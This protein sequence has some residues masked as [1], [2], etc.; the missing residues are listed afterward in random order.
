MM[1][2][3]AVVLRRD[4]GYFNKKPLLKVPLMKA[5]LERFLTY[6][7]YR[8][9]GIVR[10]KRAMSTGALVDDYLT[11]VNST[12]FLLSLMLTC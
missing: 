9:P 11:L 10:A 12:A 8:N 1:M 6:L 3:L 4:F 7:M 2:T 5:L